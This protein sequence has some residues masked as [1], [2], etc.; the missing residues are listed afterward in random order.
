MKSLFNGSVS[1]CDFRNS[2]LKSRNNSST[3]GR[4]SFLARTSNIFLAYCFRVLSELCKTTWTIPLLSNETRTSVT[5]ARREFSRQ[6]KKNSFCSLQCVELVV[7]CIF[8]TKFYNNRFRKSR[9]ICARH[10]YVSSLWNTRFEFRPPKS[11]Y[12]HID[13][14]RISVKRHIADVR[15]FLEKITN[16]HDII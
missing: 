10:D 13:V 9:L 6:E 12:L 11:V 14:S 1:N 8:H 16:K 4:F 3:F 5:T 2:N 7:L 15:T